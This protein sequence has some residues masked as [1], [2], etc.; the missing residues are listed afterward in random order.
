MRETVFVPDLVPDQVF[1][2]FCRR[3][4]G[5][6]RYGGEHGGSVP[7]ACSL[8]EVLPLT[9]AATAERWGSSAHTNGLAVP[10]GRSASGTKMLDLQSDG[11]HL[12][13]AG[14][15]GSGKSELLRSITLALALSYPPERVN[16]FFIDFKGGSGLGPLSG[17]VH[18]VGL[19]T[20]LSGSEMERTLTSLRAEVQAP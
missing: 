4:A 5:A 8:D 16:F 20:D 18:C 6:P 13:V 7:V 10:L 11:P 19:Q 3:M 15:T 1:T 17:L 14:T 2:G 12:L 9:L